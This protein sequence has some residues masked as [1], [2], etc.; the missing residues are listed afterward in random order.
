[1]IGGR[2]DVDHFVRFSAGASWRTS[3]T[4]SFVQPPRITMSGM[5][6]YA[7]MLQE[8][9]KAT[10]DAEAERAWAGCGRSIESIASSDRRGLVFSDHD[11]NAQYIAHAFKC[12]QTGCLSEQI[13]RHLQ[14]EPHIFVVILPGPVLND[15]IVVMAGFMLAM[16]RLLDAGV[17]VVLVGTTVPSLAGAFHL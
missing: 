9:S 3:K 4:I 13:V 15:H 16:N 2:C 11:C 12:A 8:M 14:S 10:I 7:P 1:M 6:Y 17:R 5:G